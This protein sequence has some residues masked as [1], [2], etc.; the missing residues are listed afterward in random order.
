M[1]SFSTE[2]LRDIYKKASR[3]FDEA[4]ERLEKSSTPEGAGWLY[5]CAEFALSV[6]QLAGL[7][8]DNR[9]EIIEPKDAQS[10]GG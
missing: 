10:I 3:M 5:Q 4:M 6:Q 1:R 8:I 2:H 9:G 7:E